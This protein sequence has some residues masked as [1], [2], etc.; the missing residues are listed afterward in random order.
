MRIAVL[1]NPTAGEEVLSRRKL[2]K[3]L[4]QHGHECIYHSTKEEGQEEIRSDQADLV[5][6]AGGDGTVAKGAKLVGS[7][8]PLVILPLGTANNIAL[9][10]GIQGTPEEIIGSLDRVSLRAFDLATATGPWGST[11]FVEST[12]VGLFASLLREGKEET[13]TPRKDDPELDPQAWGRHRLRG[14]L[15]RMAPRTCRVELDGK[16]LSGDYLMVAAM[17]ISHIG[18][19]LRLAPGADP[20]DGQLDLILVRE[21]DRVGF[22]TW[23]DEL[24]QGATPEFPV[25]ARTGRK[26]RIEWNGTAGHLDDELWPKP[27]TVDCG[28]GMVTLEISNEPVQMLVREAQTPQLRRSSQ[29]TPRPHRQK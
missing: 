29:S 25:R 27:G 6:V 22:T 9:S 5:L 15:N 14:L 3:L 23:L 26:I 12:G 13:G 18:P 21:D 4:R 8:R 17:N 16:D 28:E 1:H 7:T 2:E 11:P 10:L 24:L 19:R 20:G